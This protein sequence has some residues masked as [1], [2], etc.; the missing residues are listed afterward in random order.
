M[1]FSMR[2]F[3]RDK[4]DWRICWVF[5]CRFAHLGESQHR[6]DRTEHI[7]LANII[8]LWVK[9]VFPNSIIPP[10]HVMLS[11]SFLYCFA[12]TIHTFDF[13]QPL[14]IHCSLWTNVHGCSHSVLSRETSSCALLNLDI[15]YPQTT[16]Y[17]SF[18]HSLFPHIS[19]PLYRPL[20][21]LS[22][23][24][25]CVCCLG[26]SLYS[27]TRGLAMCCLKDTQAALLSFFGSLSPF[28]SPLL[29]SQLLQ[30]HCH[31]YPSVYR[32][33]LPLWTCRFANVATPPCFNNQNTSGFHV[34]KCSCKKINVEF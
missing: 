21:W 22:C 28:P 2:G 10:P 1:V 34:K 27:P 15:L 8:C 3:K 4:N 19:S 33:H 29:L 12:V 7:N 13:E 17:L 31:Q 23:H 6:V 9:H 26:Y 14:S 32:L 24:W 30:N 5:P 20:P 16:F 11:I 18:C 25:T